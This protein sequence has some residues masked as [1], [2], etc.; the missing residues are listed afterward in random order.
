M[1]ICQ[2]VAMEGFVVSTD[3]QN[4]NRR[5]QFVWFSGIFQPVQTLEKA[6]RGIVFDDEP[7]GLF[8]RQFAKHLVA[9]E[10]EIPS[11]VAADLLQSGGPSVE[12]TIALAAA[13]GEPFRHPPQPVGE[14]ESYVRPFRVSF[15]LVAVYVVLDWRQVVVP[16][17]VTQ[18]VAKRFER[19]GIAAD[20]EDS[21]KL[22]VEIPEISDADFQ[23]GS[24]H[25]DC[26]RESTLVDSRIIY[27]LD[28]VDDYR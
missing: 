9:Q 27:D 2:P 14:Q 15:P 22:P 5:N 13:A 1:T 25:I 26:A 12:I 6:D 18:R 16:R 8:G 24:S 4:S 21:T 28:L 7:N 19:F 10:M 17:K 11:A 23:D 20:R 3:E